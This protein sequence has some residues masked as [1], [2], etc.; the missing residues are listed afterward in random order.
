MAAAKSRKAND[1]KAKE[2]KQ[3]KILGV[4]LVLLVLLMFVQL[5]KLM[6]RGG[7]VAAAPPI[8]APVATS[9]AGAVP[10]TAPTTLAPPEVASA[11]STAATP[12]DS[13]GLADTDVSPTAA[14]GQLVQFDLFDSKDPF[15]QQVTD[16]AAE[17]AAVGSSSPATATPAPVKSA[18]DAA[19]AASA[20]TA[21][22]AAIGG[23]TSASPA[24]GP[25]APAVPMT[26][27]GRL[28]VNGA[29]ETV[30]AKAVFPAAAPTFQV[31]S[32]SASALTISILGGS[33]QDGAA[34]LKL[35]KGHVV[36]LMNTADGTRYRLVFL[37]ASKV[38][39][40]D[41]PKPVVP[42]T[43]TPAATGTTPATAAPAATVPTATAPTATTPTAPV[44]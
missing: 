11:G 14:T 35:A 44:G 30:V 1:L 38:P 33:Y 26:L 18:A 12:A 27:V 34:A 19:S 10:A 13:S 31:D 20:P 23:F 43:T 9:A 4:G 6:H 41:A 2:A 32:I 15:V 7:N 17:A 29:P 39:T 28:T 25:S 24:T 21:S 3:K 40:S 16:L 36:T 8:P 42:T 37:G 5:P 22:A